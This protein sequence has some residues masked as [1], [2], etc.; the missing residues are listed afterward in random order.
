MV[1]IL[2]SKGERLIHQYL[3]YLDIPFEEEYIFSDLTAE[4]GKPLRFDFC[5]FDDD[6]I[7]DKFLRLEILLCL[8]EMEIVRRKCAKTLARIL[9]HLFQDQ[10]LRRG[11][12]AYLSQ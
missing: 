5:L 4:N 9:L 6:V 11:K 7:Y 3:E 10:I 1:I 8:D 12:Q 2:S